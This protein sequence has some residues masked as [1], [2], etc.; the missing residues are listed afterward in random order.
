MTIYGI[1]YN[2]N[3]SKLEKP[4]FPRSTKKNEYILIV[5]L[6]KNIM[7]SIKNNWFA[8]QSIFEQN[9]FLSKNKKFSIEVFK[10]GQK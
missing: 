6:S 5:K 8:F 7:Q 2:L 4:R 10:N 3:Y 1:Y 9:R